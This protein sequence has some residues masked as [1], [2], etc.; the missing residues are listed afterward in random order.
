MVFS[1]Q[2]TP[3]A[4]LDVFFWFQ[5]TVS[6]AIKRLCGICSLKGNLHILQ[7]HLAWEGFRSTGR[8]RSRWEEKFPPA[9]RWLIQRKMLL[10]G[11]PKSCLH[12]KISCSGGME[13]GQFFC[14]PL[15]PSAGIAV[16]EIKSYVVEI[17]NKTKVR[18]NHFKGA[19]KDHV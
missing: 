16:V 7:N 17:N 2:M 4:P 1:T 8:Q 10:E 9:I 6:S 18:F 15:V 3:M 13:E 12:G 5:I 19:G 11:S 14:F